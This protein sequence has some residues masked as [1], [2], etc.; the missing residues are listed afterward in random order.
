MYGSIFVAFAFYKK[1]F[2]NP[3]L[4]AMVLVG[5]M[6]PGETGYLVGSNKSEELEKLQKWKLRDHEYRLILR[7]FSFWVVRIESIT[8]QIFD[9]CCFLKK[10]IPWKFWVH[11]FILC[12]NRLFM[13]FIYG[14]KSPLAMAW[15]VQKNSGFCFYLSFVGEIIFWKKKLIFYY[16]LLKLIFL[17]KSFT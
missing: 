13:V 1:A 8:F 7:L 12:E 4:V 15:L 10:H 3:G 11:L 17:C 9:L 14:F 5:E 2:A 6:S 16:L